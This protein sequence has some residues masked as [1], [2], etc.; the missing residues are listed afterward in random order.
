M[1]ERRTAVEWLASDLKQRGVE[2]IATLCGH[3]LDPLFEAA[4]RQEIRLIDTR[5]EQTAAYIADSFGRLTGRPGVCC[6]SSGV[7]VANALSG[8][9]NAWFDGA[10]ML[11]ISDSGPLATAGMGHFQDLDQV[12]LASPV[13]NFSRR[14]DSPDRVLSVLD[15]AWQAA[16]GPQPGP[17]H[18]MFPMDVQTAETVPLPR[19]APPAALQPCADHARIALEL[20]RA[21]SPL[22]VAGSGMHYA[23]AGNA[24]MHFSE[25]YAVPVVTPIWDRGCVDRPI[26]GFLGVIGAA[27]GGPPLL[28]QSDCLLLAGASVD[29]RLGYLQPGAVRA[30]AAILR[31]DANWSALEEAYARLG[32]KRHKGWLNAARAL[33]EDFRN[34]VEQRAAEQAGSG[35]HARD[36]IASIRS[37]APDDTILLIDAGSVGQWAHQLL[38]DRYAGYWLTCGR[39]GVV[40]WGIGGAMAARLAYPRRPVLLLCGDGAFTFNVADL[41]CAVRQRLPFV[42]I[43]ADDQAWGITRA[44]HIRQFGQALGSSLGPIAFDRLAESLGCRSMR[45]QSPEEIVRAVSGAFARSEVT[46]VHVPIVGGTP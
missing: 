46:V 1:S 26:A 4:A 36:I 28:A 3:G 12:A 30:D 13:T 27:S 7:A 21:E 33:R 5:N 35:L 22:I 31:M 24:L 18:I 25:R 14:I 19:R 16:I 39:S 9:V 11:L 37:A 42:A 8:V 17:A 29:Y 40:G 34:G 38:C 43:V 45:A 20:N 6:V 44:G 2:W 32:G 23:S 41:E 15:A 10:P